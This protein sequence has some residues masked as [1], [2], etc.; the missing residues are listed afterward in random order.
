V[1]REIAEVE[2]DALRQQI[3]EIYA[4]ERWRL[5]GVLVTPAAAVSRRRKGS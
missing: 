4:S 3:E 5:G 1:R 2:R